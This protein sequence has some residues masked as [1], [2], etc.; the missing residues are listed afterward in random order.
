MKKLLT[1]VALTAVVVLAG[2]TSSPQA[3]TGQTGGSAQDLA[4]YDSTVLTVGSTDG[5]VKGQVGIK[6][7]T[8]SSGGAYLSATYT[9]LINE[10]L[11]KN[12]TGANG[13][14]YQYVGDMVQAT[15]P[16]DAEG[17]VTGIYCNK[18]VVTTDPFS[19]TYSHNQNCPAFNAGGATSTFIWQFSQNFASYAELLATT[20]IDLYSGA[21]AWEQDPDDAN[22][23]TMNDDKALSQGSKA[24]SFVLTFTE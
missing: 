9:L 21:E 6:V 14:D 10:A 24:A 17:S 3:G 22:T 2:C 16:T 15:S 13:F 1:T 12:K 5:K 20:Q 18:D 4:Q 23:S 19:L 8:N 7:K 11:P